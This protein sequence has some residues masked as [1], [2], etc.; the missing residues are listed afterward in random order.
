MKLNARS[1][2]FEFGELFYP[3]IFGLRTTVFC[4]DTFYLEIYRHTQTLVQLSVSRTHPD[5]VYRQFNFDRAFISLQQGYF[6][7]PKICHVHGTQKT[8]TQNCVDKTFI[9]HYVSIIK[10][11]CI[12]FIVKPV[13]D[14]G[15]LNKIFTQRNPWTNDC[16]SLQSYHCHR[17]TLAEKCYR[18]LNYRIYFYNR[19]IMIIIIKLS[20]F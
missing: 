2:V 8:L 5:T 17:R 3:H 6:R 15:L 10:K 9:L 20:D 18:I 14:S 13:M 11:Y 19:Q 16:W 12:K 7:S 4:Q 1:P